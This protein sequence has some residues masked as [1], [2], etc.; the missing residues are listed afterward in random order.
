MARPLRI[1]GTSGLIEMSDADL[2]RICY[3]LRV[4]YANQLNSNGAGR[5]FIG[6]TDTVIGTASD[7]SSTQEVA[8]NPRNN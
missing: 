4:A 7:T 2:D 6:A 8:S 3:Y 5:I 1:D